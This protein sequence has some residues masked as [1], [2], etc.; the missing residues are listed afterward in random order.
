MDALIIGGPILIAITFHEAAHGFAAYVSG[1]PTARKMGRLTL[2]PIKHLDLVGTVFLP[3]TL[4][5]LKAPFLFGYAKPVPIN[6]IQFWHYRINLIF[7]A[8][9]GPLANIGLAFLSWM[10]LKFIYPDPAI[11]VQALI[12]SI[13]IN[14]ILAVF[15]MLPL[16]PLDGGRVLS[17]LLPHPYDKKYLKL[18]KYGFPV[19]IALIAMPILF[20]G[21]NPLGSFINGGIS[22]LKN[23]L[24]IEY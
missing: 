20:V 18:E 24:G 13:Q 14:L 19:L 10:M 15:N 8:A 5:L 16:L 3:L 4:L 12:Y 2:N 11:L 9:A 1:D 23:M 22:L 17:A 21:F 7:V 6:P